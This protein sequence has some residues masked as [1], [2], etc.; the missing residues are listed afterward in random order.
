MLS[1][2]L[3]AGKETANVER[4]LTSK[5]VKVVERYK[6][7]YLHKEEL[8][9]KY[10]EADRLLYVCYEDSEDYTLDLQVISE[11][12]KTYNNMFKFKTIIFCIEKII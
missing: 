7:L 6:N 11:L 12:L 9:T 10:T 4:F 5:G 2:V 1:V 3:V 8:F